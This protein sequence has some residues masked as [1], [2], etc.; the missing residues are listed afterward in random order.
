MALTD[1]IVL[2]AIVLMAIAFFCRNSSRRGTS[3]ERARHVRG[4][5]MLIQAAVAL[6]AALL[7]LQRTFAAPGEIPVAP[8]LSPRG[9][10]V[11]VFVLALAGCLWSVRGH[12]LLKQRRLFAC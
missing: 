3:T 12:Q 9:A 4:R 1:W 10:L 2:L 5:R 8:Y 6:W 7:M 11:V